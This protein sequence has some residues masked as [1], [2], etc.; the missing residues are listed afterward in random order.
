M[1][2]GGA[3]NVGGSTN[4]NA[5]KDAGTNG[6]VD[7]GLINSKD[8]GSCGCRVPGRTRNEPGSLVALAA[9]GLFC[10]R[11]RRTRD[12]ARPS[13]GPIVTSGTTH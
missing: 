13:D 11:R 2:T 4:G 1:G 7:A 8:T 6:S 10:L 3:A 9:L 5:G 12:S